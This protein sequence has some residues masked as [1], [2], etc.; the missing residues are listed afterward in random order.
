[1]D[2]VNPRAVI[3]NNEP[4]LADRLAANHADLVKRAVEAID[5]VP[6]QV[7]AIQ[8]DEEAQAYTDTAAD[9]KKVLK[10]ADA[11]FTPEK[12]PWL[13]GADTVDSFFAFRKKLKASADRA[14]GAI[15]RWRDLQL[16][17]RR[18]AEAAEAERLRKEAE[19][20]DEPPPVAAPPPKP[21]EVTR[22]VSTSGAMA[23]GGVKWDYR[24]VDFNA[25]PHDYLAENRPAITA[26]IAGLKARGIDVKDAKIPGLEIF[27]TMRTAIR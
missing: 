9:I 21:Q 3:G 22:I 1:M 2:A 8:S 24:I 17:A 20:F 23:S 19:A 26:A 16:A 18:K 25:I 11:A 15:N 7:R 14:V 13:D 27:E 6:E 12:K 4:P 5:L 10:E